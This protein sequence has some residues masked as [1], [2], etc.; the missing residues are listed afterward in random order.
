MVTLAPVGRCIRM[1]NASSPPL[2][3][4][5]SILREC[6]DQVSSEIDHGQASEAA[7]VYEIQVLEQQLANS[8]GPPQ[9]SSEVYQTSG[10]SSARDTELLH[11]L[12]IVK[13]RLQEQQ[14]RTARQW[15]SMG[16]LQKLVAALDEFSTDFLSPHASPPPP[17]PTTTAA[18]PRFHSPPTV[19]PADNPF[20]TPLSPPP[21]AYSHDAVPV[22][23]PPTD[24]PAPP[25]QLPEIP[26]HAASP[27]FA[28]PAPPTYLPP[29]AP[30]FLC[31]PRRRPPP[32]PRP[33]RHRT[34]HLPSPRRFPPPHTAHTPIV[35]CHPHRC[36]THTQTPRPPVARCG[37]QPLASRST[38]RTTT[39]RRSPASWPRATPA[40]KPSALASPMGFLVRSFQPVS[41]FFDCN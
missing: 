7:L 40:P 28:L 17:P 35:L 27:A 12:G 31:P 39:P 13:W 34:H 33:P 8:K 26:H 38:R 23:M 3:F 6:M 36:R 16:E 2:Y 19:P 24:P 4:Y 41:L 29:D 22:S 32:S 10:A 37:P 25:P 20:V 1:Q 30:V 5:P 21:P 18:G 9:A 15:Y 11:Q 14:Q